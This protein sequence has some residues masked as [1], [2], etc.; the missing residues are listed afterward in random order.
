MRILRIGAALLAVGVVAA[1]SD[2]PTAVDDAAAPQFAFHPASATSAPLYALAAPTGA[3]NAV[4]Q[5]YTIDPTSG[6]ATLVGSTGEVGLRGIAADPSSG[7][8]YSSYGSYLATS[9]RGIVR[10]D[11]STGAVTAIGGSM[12]FVSLAFDSGGDLYGVRNPFSVGDYQSGFARIFKI[13]VTTG[14]A[15]EVA[16]VAHQCNTGWQI[17]FNSADVLYFKDWNYRIWRDVLGT[18]TYLGR[19]SPPFYASL[20]WDFDSNDNLYYAGHPVIN[21]E[22]ATFDLAAF[23]ATKIGNTGIRIRGLSFLDVIT[24][25]IDIKPGSDPNSINTKNK[26]VIPVAILGSANF[27][28]SDVDVTTL[29]FGPGGATPA[30]K[31][32][33]HVEDVNDDGFDDLVSHYPT[34]DAGLSSGDTEACVDGATTGGMT[35]RGCDAVRIVR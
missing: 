28:V 21:D 14:N 11:A 4:M 15:V 22:W 18:V 26:G 29:T 1:C 10:I 30:H 5:L 19:I 13:D 3:R 2:T 16:K 24:V 20:S 31:A 17:A 8:L 33:G 7:D 9:K 12:A 6:A 35:I 25:D 34:Q 27:D 23:T 32:G